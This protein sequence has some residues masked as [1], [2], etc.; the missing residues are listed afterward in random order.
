[1]A[2]IDTSKTERFALYQYAKDVVH[3]TE[4]DALAA[5]DERLVKALREMMLVFGSA[6]S[7]QLA[8]FDESRSALG[9]KGAKW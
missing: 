4:Y 2:L 7:K 3:A 9:I 1:M 8:A 5:Q 6:F